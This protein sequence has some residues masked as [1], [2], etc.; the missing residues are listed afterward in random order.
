MSAESAV[1]STE[2]LVVPTERPVVVAERSVGAA[3][4]PGGDREGRGVAPFG[5]D[6]GR[7]TGVSCGMDAVEFGST[8]WYVVMLLAG[9]AVGV[10]VALARIVFRKDE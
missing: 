9:V 5:R 1:V 2:R 10:A 4:R 8:N 6:T 3:G 7:E